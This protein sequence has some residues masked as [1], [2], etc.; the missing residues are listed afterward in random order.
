MTYS[1]DTTAVCE[2]TGE[3]INTW[4]QEW[5]LECEARHILALNGLDR[6]AWGYGKKGSTERG[7]RGLMQIRGEAGAKVVIEWVNR[8]IDARAA[9]K[10][11]S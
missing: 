10:A 4:S 7:D 6:H 9:K 3:P 11:A 5:A 8:L 1:L 2:I